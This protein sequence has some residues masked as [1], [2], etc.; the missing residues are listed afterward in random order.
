MIRFQFVFYFI[1]LDQIWTENKNKNLK[2]RLIHFDQFT[3]C[4][5]Q[6]TFQIVKMKDQNPIRTSRINCGL[7]S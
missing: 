3:K 6:M 5:L 4:P 1:A 7:A 2:L